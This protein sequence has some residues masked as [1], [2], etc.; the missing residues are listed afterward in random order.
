[1]ASELSG[2]GSSNAPADLGRVVRVIKRDVQEEVTKDAFG[3]EITR[4]Q[5]RTEILEVETKKQGAIEDLAAAREDQFAK[6][7]L[8]EIGTRPGLYG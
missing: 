2:I 7:F 1:M 3:A 6:D 8:D 4:R 5:I